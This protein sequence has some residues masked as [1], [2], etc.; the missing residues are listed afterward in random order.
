MFFILYY[1]FYYINYHCGAS[2]SERDE[3]KKLKTTTNS[4]TNT[5]K[6]NKKN[7][8][9][10]AFSLVEMLVVIAVIGIIAAIAVPQ[11]GKINEKAEDSKKKRNAQNIASVAAGAA[12][13]GL[14]FV[15]VS[16]NADGADASKVIGAVVT[17]GKPT[18]GPFKDTFFGVPSLSAD[19]QKDADDYLEV[20][21]GMVV[22]TGAN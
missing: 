9:I 8:L 12:A 5:M 14:D 18:D 13:A 16:T 21:N 10:A 22:Y 4:P 17:G 19:E 6:L 15:A 20:A 3:N 11:I 1:G 2:L 7:P